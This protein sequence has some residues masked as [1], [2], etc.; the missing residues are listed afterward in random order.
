MLNGLCCLGYL[1]NA[2]NL[3]GCTQFVKKPSILCSSSERI[4]VL[5]EES[6]EEKAE[7]QSE[8]CVNKYLA[9]V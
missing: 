2:M 3:T 9:C 8:I 1:W 4:Y 6:D 5:T 7:I